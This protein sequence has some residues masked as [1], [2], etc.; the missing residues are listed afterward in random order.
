M[1]IVIKK[2]VSL[3]FLG[4]E[5]KDAY[6]VFQSIPLKDFDK[7]SVEIEEA[8][9]D[10]KAAIFILNS[11]K[12]YFIEGKFPDLDKVTAEDLDGLD[13]EAV[14]RCF[15]RFTGQELDPKE[16]TPSPTQS[17]TNPDGPEN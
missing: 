14:I 13:Q 3:D 1:P 10:K 15:Q 11:L 12:K 6:L 16:N 2:K 7:L 5:Y 4:E 17:S 9:K 8:Q